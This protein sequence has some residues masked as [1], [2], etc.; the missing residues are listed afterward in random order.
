[1]NWNEI[2]N[3][4]P[5][6]SASITYIAVKADDPNTVWVTF[7]GYGSQNIF[8]TTD[9]GE[10]WSDISG[11][12]P[13]VPTMC[14]VQN[15]FVPDS[16]QL[17]LG[18]DAGVYYKN[19]NADWVLYSQGLPNVVVTELEIY[20]NSEDVGQ[21]KLRAATYGRGL[22]ESS[23]VNVG[24]NIPIADFDASSTTIQES[25]MVSFID[26]S[27]FSPLS[28]LWKFEGGVPDTSIVQNPSV[29]YDSIG[30]F[31]VSLTVTNAQGSNLLTKGGFIKVSGKL[32]V[33]AFTADSLSG[34]APLEV[35]FIDESQ[36]ADHWY[37]DF[38]DGYYSEEQ[39]PRHTFQ[40]GAFNI[41]QVAWNKYGSDTLLVEGMI[42]VIPS[43]IPDTWRERLVVYPNPADRLVSIKL[44]GIEED[45][46][47][48]SLIDL[49]GKIILQQSVVKDPDYI[50][51]FDVVS[52]PAGS[53]VVRIQG[54]HKMVVLQLIV[55]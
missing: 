16:I 36:G 34:E 24:G 11:V 51:T 6:T 4:L 10:T 21:S 54:Y 52:L 35:Q 28:W 55:E 43:D 2:T 41:Q 25:E 1:M 40:E 37:W 19:G 53:Y 49:S 14:V 17:Y 8:E 29:I 23:I 45:V 20:Y 31:S 39:N 50:Y 32:P 12:L 13:S 9:A 44:N 27:L 3:T 48:I 33:A 42:V 15:K 47:M 22:W 26:E 5:V 18:T 7:G 46:D 38:G 30:L